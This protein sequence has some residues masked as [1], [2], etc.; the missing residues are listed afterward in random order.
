MQCQY[1][2]KKI[3]ICFLEFLNVFNVPN[4]DEKYAKMSEGLKKR[5]EANYVLKD[6][7]YV[8]IDCFGRSI[9]HRHHPELKTW[10][11]FEVKIMQVCC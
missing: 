7:D 9:K 4:Q 8:Y 11:I 5:I 6:T 10:L 1:W 2:H 3:K